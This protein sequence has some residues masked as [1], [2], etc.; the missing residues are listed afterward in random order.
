MQHR[1]LRMAAAYHALGVAT[2]EQLIKSADD[3]LNDGVYSYSLGELA[4]AR[5]PRWADCIRL[6]ES[7]MEELESSIPDPTSA[8]DTLLE[9]HVVRLVEGLTTAGEMLQELHAV[10]F[11]LIYPSSAK[12]PPTALAPL[13]PF[14][15]Q[16]HIIEEI[17]EYRS[18]REEQALPHPEDEGLGKAHAEVMSMAEAW[19]RSRWQPT[20][21]LSWF[22]STV[23]ALAHGI[24][25]D[26]AFDRLP[27][28]ADALQDAGC[29]DE[30]IL[31]HLRMSGQHLRCCFVVELLCG[32]C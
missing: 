14:I 15:D 7:A 22:T 3:A 5:D 25:T 23:V 9:C 26:R 1:S 21:D 4:T 6:F 16:Y 29:D 10:E 27:I 8:V 19:C 12:V 24:A 30:C 13:Q 18:Y 17:V 20:L 32:A 31:D 11:A 2:K 28:L